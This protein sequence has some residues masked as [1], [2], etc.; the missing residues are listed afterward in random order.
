LFCGLAI[1]TFSNL[2]A[3]RSRLIRFTPVLTFAVALTQ[4]ILAEKQFY[5]EVSAD[6]ASRIAYGSNPFPESVKIAEYLRDHSSVSDTIA[7]L[8][9]EPQ[10]YFYSRR[11]S[12]TGYIYTYSLMEAQSY[13]RRMQEEMIREIEN[14]RPRYLISVS[15][16]PSWNRHSD[17]EP[18]IFSWANEYLNQ[19]YKVVGF[20]N[21]LSADRTDYY[22]GELPASMPELGGYI[23][24]YERAS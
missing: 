21:I 7:I 4:P 9:S 22:F 11:H 6:E 15:M 16:G 8:G 3:S 18:L 12:A 14:A 5:F 10:I 17:S 13:A 20:V 24:I 2:V 19:H 23:L 1:S